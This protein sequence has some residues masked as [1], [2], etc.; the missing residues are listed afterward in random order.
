[1]KGL[2]ISIGGL[3]ESVV[4]HSLNAFNTFLGNLGLNIKV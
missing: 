3:T 2:I 4:K 1:M